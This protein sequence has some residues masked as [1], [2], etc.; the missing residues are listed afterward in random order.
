MRSFLAIAALIL[1]APPALAERA[2]AAAPVAAGAPR[3]AARPPVQPAPPP[4]QLAPIDPTAIAEPCRALARQALAPGLAAALSARISLASCMVERAIAP[5]QLCD[6]G[7]S[8]IAID[9]ATA[10]ALAV[11]DDV[12]DVADPAVQVIAEHTEG[13][14]YAGFATRLLATLP[15]VAPGASDAELALRDMR[16]QTLEAQLAPWREAALASFQHVV[17]IVKAHPEIAGVPAVVTAVR[18]SARQL[19]ASVAAR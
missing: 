1:I 2:P 7:Q 8:I 19:A 9:A 12:I 11:L 5:L 18:D 17:D 3:A 15:P 14:L 4:V 6:C 16:R 13:G 10:P